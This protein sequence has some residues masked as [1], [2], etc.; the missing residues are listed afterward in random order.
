MNLPHKFTAAENYQYRLMRIPLK[1][2]ARS[3]TMDGK[4]AVTTKRLGRMP[5]DDNVGDVLMYHYPNTWNHV[6]AD[7]ALSFR[8]I[9][10]SPTETELVTKWLVPADA[11]EGVDYDIDNLTKV[12]NAT[13]MQDKFL[14]E[15]NQIGLESP[16]YEPSPYNNIHEDEVNQFM[17]WYCESLKKRCAI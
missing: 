17:D 2:D 9:P 5:V 8:M 12:W 7:H 15:R 10:I 13:N 4:P 14:V 1:G 16:A 3:F 11:I 6:L